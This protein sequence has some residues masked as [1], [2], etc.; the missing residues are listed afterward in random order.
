MRYRSLA[1]AVLA[2]CLFAVA[3]PAQAP[4][5]KDYVNHQFN[6][7]MQ[8]PA[9]WQGQGKNTASGGKALVF[10]GPAGGEEYFTTINVQV[11]KAGPGA[12]VQDQARDFAKQIATAPKYKIISVT[13]GDLAGAP[14]VR[15]QCVYQHP[16]NKEIF[17]QDQIIALKGNFFLWLGFTAPKNLYDKY[18]PLMDRC[19]ASFAFLQQRQGAGPK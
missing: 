1:A 6:F 12:K 16:K 8:L 5:F 7:R 15:I 19:L 14:A 11:V 3:A 2:I 18:H 4:P 9:H 17:R 13:E 10:S